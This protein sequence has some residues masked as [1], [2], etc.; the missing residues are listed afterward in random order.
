MQL[1]KHTKVLDQEKIFP[2]KCKKNR[3]LYLIMQHNDPITEGFTLQ[4]LKFR[5]HR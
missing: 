4:K 3:R 1:P 5:R 2:I